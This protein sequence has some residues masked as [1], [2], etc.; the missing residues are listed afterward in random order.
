MIIVRIVN[1]DVFTLKLENIRRGYILQNSNP[2][3]VIVNG[4]IALYNIY[5][6]W[7]EIT[8]IYD[9]LEHYFVMRDSW[10]YIIKEHGFDEN[11]I[12]NFTACKIN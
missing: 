9:L 2:I 10:D 8:K 4:E 12:L 6:T 1:E 11:E 7:N 3:G 5:F